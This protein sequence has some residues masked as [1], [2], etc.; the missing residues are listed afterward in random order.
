MSDRVR[1]QLQRLFPIYQYLNFNLSGTDQDKKADYTAFSHY[2]FRVTIRDKVHRHKDGRTGVKVS[3]SA[4]PPA[5]HAPVLPDRGVSPRSCC[6]SRGQSNPALGTT[7]EP[8]QTSPPAHSSLRSQELSRCVVT[9]TV[10][11]QPLNTTEKWKLVTLKYKVLFTSNIYSRKVQDGSFITIFTR[12]SLQCSPHP[13]HATAMDEPLCLFR[14]LLNT[15]STEYCE[16]K[17]TVKYTNPCL[18]FQHIFPHM[19]DLQLQRVQCLPYRTWGPD[20]APDM[21][22]YKRKIKQPDWIT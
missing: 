3:A 12:S 15:H 16:G 11:A 14:T 8:A 17:M 18:S 9:E 13:S 5:A 6:S 22:E 20:M 21:P 4:R 1:A 2:S 19:Q 7:R 10:T